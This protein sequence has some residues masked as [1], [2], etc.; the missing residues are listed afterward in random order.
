MYTTKKKF[1]YNFIF[2]DIFVNYT[3]TKYFCNVVLI[4]K[5]RWLTHE[6]PSLPNLYILDFFYFTFYFYAYT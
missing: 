6:I 1:K 5:I 3:S 4:E 2:I